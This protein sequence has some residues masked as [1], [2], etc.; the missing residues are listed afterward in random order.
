MKATDVI[1]M[2]CV[3]LKDFQ[4]KA[5]KKFNKHDGLI[6]ANTTQVQHQEDISNLKAMLEQKMEQDRAELEAKITKLDI[7]TT[8]TSDALSAAL[9]VAE[10]DNYWKIKD[11]EKLL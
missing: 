10:S 8:E 11:I 6:A 9:K 1:G 2:S 3:E 7:S 4:H 5:E